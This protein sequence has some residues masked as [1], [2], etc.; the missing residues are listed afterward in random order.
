MNR[1][2]TSSAGYKARL[3]LTHQ[4]FPTAELELKGETEVRLLGGTPAVVGLRD[5]GIGPAGTSGVGALVLNTA[6]TAGVLGSVMK[7]RANSLM[8]AAKTAR[9]LGS[10]IR[11][12]AA[13]SLMPL[14]RSDRCQDKIR[15]GPHGTCRSYLRLAFH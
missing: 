13:N 11:P 6:K 9:V 14:R 4:G 2:C 10:T 1:M 7:P 12:R 3:S 8:D 15:M 5:L